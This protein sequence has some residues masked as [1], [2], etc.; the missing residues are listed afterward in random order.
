MKKIVLIT[1]MLQPYRITF[2]EKLSAI[3]QEFQW[4]IF[5][6]VARSEVGR[7]SY[8]GETNFEQ[9]GFD[10]HKTRIGPFTLVNNRG[11]YAATK[12]I[13][14]DLIILQG[15]T[16]DISNRRVISWAK[17]KGIKIIVWTCGW[18]PGLAKGMLLSFKNF[19]VGTFFKKADLHLTYSTAANSYVESMGVSPEKVI[20]S[21]NGIEIDH[22][23]K[24]E[25]NIITKAQDIRE[26]YELDGHITFL[27]VGGLIP[28]KRVD[29]LLQAFHNLRQNHKNIKLLI[30]GDGPSRSQVQEHMEQYNDQHIYYLGRIIDG[31]DPYFA[32]SDCFVLPGV[33]G[34]ALNQAMFWR[35]TCIVS[36]AD[37]TED[38][39]VIEK[40]TGFRF[41][42]DSLESLMAAMERRILT[43]HED[44]Q[45]MS[46]KSREIIE[47][48]SNV[49]SMVQVFISSVREL[50]SKS[51]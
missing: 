34:L 25:N 42:K 27:Y 38:D 2:Y 49:N 37:G 32:A 9:M 33:G 19:L 11:L 45:S 36:E 7:P 3:D 10:E 39:L 4:K 46:E 41:E 30:I 8:K 26:K 18:E 12:K 23:L 20:T 35:K 17:R 16:G 43:S 14:P 48:K 24:E 51:K 29:L 40:V 13:N 31:V 22:L 6:G 21:Y 1:P 50:L 15:I 47:T 5:H 28:E 44:M